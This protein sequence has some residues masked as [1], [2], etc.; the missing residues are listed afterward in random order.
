LSSRKLLFSSDA[1][2]SPAPEDFVQFLISLAAF[3]YL[4]RS[5]FEV[6]NRNFWCYLFRS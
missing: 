6:S 1:R 2:H 3:L 4:I 5:S